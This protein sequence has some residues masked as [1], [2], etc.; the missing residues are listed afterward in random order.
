MESFVKNLLQCAGGVIFTEAGDPEFGLKARGGA[1][2]V[3][4]ILKN[5]RTNVLQPNLYNAFVK[6]RLTYLDGS[7]APSFMIVWIVF[8]YSS[9]A[10]VSVTAQ[11]QQLSWNR[12]QQL[13]CRLGGGSG[14]EVQNKKDSKASRQKTTLKEV[15]GHMT[16]RPGLS[17]FNFV[18]AGNDMPASL[19]CQ[20]HRPA[21][22]PTSP[23]ESSRLS[24]S[25]TRAPPP[26]QFPD[27]AVFSSARRKRRYPQE[28]RSARG[29]AT[30]P[31]LLL[32]VAPN[33]WTR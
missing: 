18:S 9:L 10:I 11:Y 27:P 19:L 30:H 26:P 17:D 33:L 32:L 23:P 25:Y 16:L 5:R 4:F 14:A 20:D 29:Y 8:A 1:T 2:F 13:F 7:V 21:V 6:S 12:L 28:Y 24:G 15:H 22:V 31:P 3:R